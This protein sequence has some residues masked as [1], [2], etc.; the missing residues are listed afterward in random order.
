MADDPNTME[1]HAQTALVLLL[2]G[3][4]SWVGIT[5]HNTS[6]AV[7]SLAVEM[8]YLKQE[9]HKPADK[10]DVIERRLD[11]IEQALSKHMQVDE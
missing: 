5:T 1:R 7:A 11:A 8:Q 4:L 9:A 10:F 6:I 3:L 2:V